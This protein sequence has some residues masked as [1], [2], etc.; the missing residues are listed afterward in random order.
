MIKPASFIGVRV[1]S[2]STMKIPVDLFR[3]GYELLVSGANLLQSPFLL[4]LRIY[5]FWQLFQTGQGKLAHIEKISDYFASLGIPWPTLNAYMAGATETFGGLLL[6]IGLASRLT[7][8]PITVV[9]AVAYL[10]ADLE[11]VTGIFSTTFRAHEMSWVLP[12][13]TMFLMKHINEYNFLL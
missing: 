6:I 3:R 12:S 7:A 1:R 5:F 2:I 4:L 9:M 13:I 8:I 10:T 11:A